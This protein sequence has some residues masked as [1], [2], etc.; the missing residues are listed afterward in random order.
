MQALLGF[1]LDFWDYLT[2]LTLALV[3]VSV[4]VAY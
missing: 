2:F 1:E 4:V 3:V